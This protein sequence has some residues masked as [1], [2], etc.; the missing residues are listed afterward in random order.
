MIVERA[1]D[2]RLAGQLRHVDN[3]RHAAGNLVGGLVVAPHIQFAL[4]LAVV[5]AHDHQ[6][7][8]QNAG[9]G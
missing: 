9:V 3:Q 5:G 6:R 2:T 4:V 1:V 8:V 7:L